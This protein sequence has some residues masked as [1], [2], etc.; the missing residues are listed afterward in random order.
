M[1]PI[2]RLNRFFLKSK[3]AAKL[4]RG[5]SLIEIA[6]VLVIV[7]IALG[8]GITML[9]KQLEGKNVSDT[10]SRLKE[11]SEAIT[12]FAMVNR[13]LPCPATLLS[14]GLESIT[15]GPAGARG[16]C[17]NPNN[18]FVPSRT[19]G[20]SEQGNAGIT[21]DAWAGNLRYAVSQLTY[22]G[23]GNAPVSVS[24]VGTCYP[25]T[26]ADGVKN[27]YYLNG[28]QSTIPPAG[29][30][31]VCATAS[32]ITPTTCGTAPQISQ[33]GF[34]VWSTSRNGAAGGVGLDEA[35]NLNNDV[36]YVSHPRTEVGAANGEFDDL[37]VWQTNAAVVS[38]M[39]KAGV[40]P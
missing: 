16:Q 8:A 38:G 33:A 28:V 2:L 22:T 24:C 27:A 32:V 5:F 18:G 10:Q 9:S 23:T 11:A 25:F 17:T 37:F 4:Q 21:V 19:L 30:L 15:P 36:V 35:A 14:A 13:R 6:L 1:T 39:T 3:V 7:G 40:L 20:L 34:I 29:L 26:Q 31:R 12:A